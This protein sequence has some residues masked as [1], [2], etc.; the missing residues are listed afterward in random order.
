MVHLAINEGD[1]EHDVVVW[2][3][4]VADAEYTAHE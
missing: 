1:D 4:P 2:M 3:D